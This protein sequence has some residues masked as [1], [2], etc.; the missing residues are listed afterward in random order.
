MRR[1][2]FLTLADKGDFVIDDEHAYGP[3]AE[4][5]WQADAVPWNQ[6]AANWN[7]FE[8]VVIR[9]TW[10]YQSDP[11]LFMRVLA[12]IEASEARLAN[13]REIVRWNLRK[14]YLQELAARGVTTVPTAWRDR[15]RPGGL[16]A[17]FEELESNEIVIKPQVGANADGA[18]RLAQA[19]QKFLR[20]ELEDYYADTPLMAQ[21]FVPS[22]QQE[23]EYSLFYFN[24]EY[25]HAVLKTPRRG[26]FRCQEEH[27]ASIAAADTDAAL[28]AAGEITIAAIAEPLLYARA[29]FVRDNVSND[30][31]LMELELIEPSLYLRMDSGA[32]L[33]FA[34]AIEALMS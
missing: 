17:L 32:P 31:W 26:D 19:S 15:L 22:I 5:G 21:P 12:D 1:C 16:T 27:G 34:K 9:S 14:T 2:A 33:R 6:E 25:S 11:D 30:Y 3:L 29:D 13:T 8:L 10:D 28:Q 23:G 24:G 20:K 18:F 7:D 4:M